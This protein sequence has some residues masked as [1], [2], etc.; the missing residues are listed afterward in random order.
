MS[1]IAP[2]DDTLGKPGNAVVDDTRTGIYQI[3]A[4][5]NIGTVHG[6]NSSSSVRLQRKLDD[7]LGA[8]SC[9]R[10]IFLD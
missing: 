8:G 7:K 5:S 1:T 10:E 6:R 9:R 4:L 3:S 2:I